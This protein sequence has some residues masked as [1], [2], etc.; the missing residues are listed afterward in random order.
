MFSSSLISPPKF[1]HD[2]VPHFLRLR[3]SIQD[4]QDCEIELDLSA[5][6]FIDPLGLC[7]VKHWFEELQIRGVKITLSQW[8]LSIESFLRR[9]DLFEGLDNLHFT[10][11]TSQNG[12]NEL[13]GQL[14]ELQS[15]REESEI[16]KAAS[17][18]A[19]S[20]VHGLPNVSSEDDGMTASPQE[21]LERNLE[22]VF[23]E[24]LL[25]ALDHGKSRGYA[26]S[27]TNISAQY[28]PKSD[29][30]DIAIVDNGCGLLQTLQQHSRME[31]DLT[32]SKAI[33]IALEP[34]VSCNRDVGM[35]EDTINQGVGLTVSCRLAFEAGGHCGI[36]SG[37]N[38]KI[39]NRNGVVRDQE[40]VPW[41]GTGVFFR[42]P[43]SGL[44]ET[45]VSNVI[46]GLP[47]YQ[48]NRMINFD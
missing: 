24:I 27:H 2:L 48:M 39:V 36:F 38:W 31:E 4:L 42:F 17:K 35:R 10:D 40:I 28:Y 12:R 26:H 11:R 21:K 33:F 5:L 7:L 41:Q 18:I 6:R 13:D 46:A 29:C 47:R 44:L 34:G 1:T 3:E 32:H 45:N 19:R 15:L 14:V 8:S 16:Q 23:S 25:N 37:S 9:V 43:K 20:I 22:Y 30:L